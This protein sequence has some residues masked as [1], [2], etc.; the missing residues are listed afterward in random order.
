MTHIIDEPCQHC[1]ED[2]DRQ[3]MFL[4]ELPLATERQHLKVRVCPTCDGESLI[5]LANSPR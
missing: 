4:V 2:K 5:K 1:K 3:T